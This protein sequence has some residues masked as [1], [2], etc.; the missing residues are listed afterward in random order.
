MMANALIPAVLNA[1]PV[2]PSMGKRAEDMSFD[3][4]LQRHGRRLV[5]YGDE[6]MTDSTGSKKR[7]HLQSLGMISSALVGM[8]GGGLVGGA[9]GGSTGAKLGGLLGLAGGMA[10]NAIGQKEGYN[11]PARSRQ[12]Q[13]AYTNGDEGILEELLVPGVAGYQR[14]R[15]WKHI[16]DAVRKEFSKKYKVSPI[17]G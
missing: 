11:Q 17:N 14:G 7:K 9:L 2:H 8:L 12:E 13:M 16:D 10:A 4:G 1:E 3:E 15:S 6:V 5:T